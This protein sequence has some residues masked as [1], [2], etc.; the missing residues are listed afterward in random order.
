MNAPQPDFS[1]LN[2]LASLH[3]RDS[4]H[5]AFVDMIRRDRKHWWTSHDKDPRAR[6]YKI[7]DD[8]L[9]ILNS[10]REINTEWEGSKSATDRILTT[11]SHLSRLY[12]SALP[13]ISFIKGELVDELEPGTVAFMS[14]MLDELQELRD[15]YRGKRK[16]NDHLRERL[17]DLTNQILQHY[18]QLTG[19]ITDDGE[20]RNICR[21]VTD[22]IEHHGGEHINAATRQVLSD[23]LRCRAGS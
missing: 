7:R 11:T 22:E 16:T 9:T 1:F 6:L 5:W 12:R 15:R 10:L 23:A 20:R 4:V 14:N 21:V 3:G 13:V 2:T 18:L 19:R 17:T 8:L